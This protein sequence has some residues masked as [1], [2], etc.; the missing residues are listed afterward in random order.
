MWNP[1]AMR[2][3]FQA[4]HINKSMFIKD[5]VTLRHINV[6]LENSDSMLISC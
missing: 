6:T 4:K 3:P 5:L 1:M 2:S